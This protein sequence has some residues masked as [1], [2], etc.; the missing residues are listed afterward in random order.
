MNPTNV[1]IYACLS[2]AQASGTNVWMM[3][4]M[5]A[6]PVHQFPDVEKTGVIR[7]GF[8]ASGGRMPSQRPLRAKFERVSV[9]VVT[10][11]Q[12]VAHH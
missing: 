2:E 6:V 9:P 7:Q 5:N 11:I 12:G 1:T 10:L 8:E 4:D 3:H